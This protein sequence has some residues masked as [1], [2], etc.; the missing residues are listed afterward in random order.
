MKNFQTL[1]RETLGGNKKSFDEVVRRFQVL[2]LG[3][4]ERRLNDTSLAQDAVQEAFLRAYVKLPDLKNL[5]SFPAWFRAILRSVCSRILNRERRFPLVSDPNSAGEIPSDDLG[6]F[7]HHAR[8]QSGAMVAA[9]LHSLSGRTR[10]ACI[11][12]FVHGRSYGEIAGMLN[13]PLGTVKRRIHDARD[14]IVKQFERMEK[15]SIQVGY[16]PISDHLLAMVAH[17]FHDQTRF[18]IKARRFLS[19]PSLIRSLVTGSLDAAFVMAP[20]AMHL[21]AKGVPLLYVLDG[22]HDGSAITV[23]GDHSNNGASRPRM[24]LPY[25]ISTHRAILRS[26]IGQDLDGRAWDAS[27]KYMSPSY[28]IGSLKKNEIDA[29]FC[30]EPW[31]TKSVAEGQGKIL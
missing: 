8:Y 16:L 4:A 26:L 12:R 30:A 7:E 17:Y 2:A 29:F 31:S 22:H 23:R 10:E 5:N 15:Y 14:K 27:A 1:L 13:V 24:G 21:R 18:R 25:M 3:L 11:E 19:W 6:P 9:L 28:L 20:L